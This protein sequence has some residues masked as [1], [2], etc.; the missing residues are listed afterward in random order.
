[1]W[2]IGIGPEYFSKAEKLRYSELPRQINSPARRYGGRVYLCRVRTPLSNTR[3]GHRTFFARHR[4]N[5]GPAVLIRNAQCAC[6]YSYFMRMF[7]QYAHKSLPLTVISACFSMPDYKRMVLCSRLYTVYMAAYLGLSS[8]RSHYSQR[9][10]SYVPLVP[11]PTRV[12]DACPDRLNGCMKNNAQ[13]NASTNQEFDVRI[14]K[15]TQG[16]EIFRWSTSVIYARNVREPCSRCVP[17]RK[18]TL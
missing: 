14:N 18:L 12:N 16:V 1:M 6:T 13:C 17:L 7:D 3:T 2:L 4:H 8:L 15:V 9:L 10:L 11:L 5:H